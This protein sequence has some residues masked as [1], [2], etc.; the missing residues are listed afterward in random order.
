ML[1]ICRNHLVLTIR[2]QPERA[3]SFRC[4][5]GRSGGTTGPPDTGHSWPSGYAALK[6]T[7]L[8][9]CFFAPDDRSGEFGGVNGRFG[10]PDPNTG[11]WSHAGVP[12]TE[13]A[14]ALLSLGHWTQ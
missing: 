14:T 5:L 4:L 3:C 10:A 6:P 11:Y 2:L 8:T 12:V 9:F 7:V 1:S 13:F